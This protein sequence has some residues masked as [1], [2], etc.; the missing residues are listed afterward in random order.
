MQARWLELLE[1]S[2]RE[3]ARANSLMAGRAG[4]W[5]NC[6]PSA[7]LSLKFRPQEFSLACLYRLGLPIYRE[8][9]SCPLCDRTAGRLGDHAVGLCPLGPDRIARHNQLRDVFYHTLVAA[10]LTPCAAGIPWLRL[11]C[12][13]I[14]R[15]GSFF[16]ATMPVSNPR[17][18]SPGPGVAA[19]TPVSTW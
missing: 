3:K 6:P 8:M 19:T 1:G 10:E 9:A 16:R 15:P 12:K 7:A 5:L 17:T 14:E 4:D 2:V 11:A 18:A 13:R